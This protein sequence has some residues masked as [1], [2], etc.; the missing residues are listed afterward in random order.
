MTAATRGRFGHHRPEPHGN[1]GLAA[2]LNWLRA[3]VLGA[4]DGIIST[5]GLVI[6]VAAF[7]G[8]GYRVPIAAIMFV[9]EATGKPEFIV[10]AVVATVV[11]ELAVGGQ[12]VTTHQL[13]SRAGATC[14]PE[15]LGDVQ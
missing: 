7:L 11:A 9:A 12:S 10:P 3:G 1:G 8:A 15:A 14:G 2:R 4:N 5:A 6:G 13:A